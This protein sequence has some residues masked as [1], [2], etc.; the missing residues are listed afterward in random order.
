MVDIYIR[1]FQDKQTNGMG[2]EGT[3]PCRYIEVNI[4]KY[5]FA[6]STTNTKSPHFIGHCSNVS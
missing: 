6:F 2:E 5:G 4:S 3:S 1:C